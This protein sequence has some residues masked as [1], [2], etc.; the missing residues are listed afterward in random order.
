MKQKTA[1]QNAE[2]SICIF[3]FAEKM[4][5][6]HSMQSQ[7]WNLIQIKGADYYYHHDDVDSVNTT[8]N[9]IS[10][11]LNLKDQ[12][13]KVRVSVIYQQ[14]KSAL[15]MNIVQIF[16]TY[17]CS[18]WQILNWENIYQFALQTF[19]Q[20]K[21]FFDDKNI[22]YTWLTENVLPLIWHEEI[23]GY[24]QRA[25][26]ALRAEKA[27][28]EQQLYLLATDQQQA[29]AEQMQKLEV[30]KQF[31]QQEIM[32]ARFQLAKLQQ[33]DVESLVTYLPAIFKDFWNIVRPDELAILANVLNVPQVSSPYHSPSLST[34]QQKK[35]QFLALSENSQEK[36]L[37][38]CRELA[39]SHNGL[40]VHQE[41]YRL[42]GDMD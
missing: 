31:L 30:D 17:Q 33:P 28:L 24:Q 40:K 5:A 26:E 32:K 19:G 10:D 29:L 23:I 9:E 15:L 1:N 35:R 37:A 11:D 14:D 3:I 38:L 16:Q 34:V 4:I 25:V 7:P 21:V 6:Y 8:F 13:A 41:F 22:E 36:I 18:V 2:H 39:H 20:D 12:L 27:E 42:V